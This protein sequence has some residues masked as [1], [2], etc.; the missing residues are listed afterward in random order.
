VNVRAILWG[1][2]SYVWPDRSTP[3]TSLADALRDYDDMR[4]F[5]R[6]RDGLGAPCWG[7]VDVPEPA[8]RTYIGHAWIADGTDDDPIGS[9]PDYVLVIGR[10]SGIRWE[11]A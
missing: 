4:T 5:Q 10:R 2:S 7:D 8:G 1:G 9:Y 6:T 11:R 3:Y